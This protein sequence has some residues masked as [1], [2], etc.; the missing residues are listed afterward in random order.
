MA[1]QQITEDNSKAVTLSDN[2]VQALLKEYGL[3][4]DN[5]DHLERVIWSTAAILV[6]G[7]ITG[8]ALLGNSIPESPTTYDYLLRT[9]IGAL[10]ILLVYWWRKMASVWYFVQNLC[11]Y[12]IV[13]IEEVL[14]LYISSY[15][16]YLDRALRGEKYPK[17]PRV[18]AM[19]SAMKDQYRPLSVPR[20]V[21]RIGLVLMAVWFVFLV[22]QII[23]ML[24]WI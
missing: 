7:S 17:R 14:D 1:A 23:I 24:G 18:E 9:A 15:I 5:A 3:A 20:T 12:R 10:S 19:I 4:Y 16:S 13:E 21:N 8:L 2:R 6:S 11:Y 22:T